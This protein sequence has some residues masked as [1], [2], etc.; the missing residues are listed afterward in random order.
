MNNWVLPKMEDLS[1]YK[2][3]VVDTETSGLYVWKGHQVLGVVLGLVRDDDKIDSRYY[4]FG[5][6]GGDQYTRQQVVE[7]L[8]RELVGKK[9]IFHNAVFDLIML[10]RMCVDLR[11]INEIHDTMFA[12]ILVNPNSFYHLD[13]M[14][15]QYVDPNVQKIVLPFPKDKM[16]EASS[17]EVGAYAELDGT[18]TGNLHPIM[19]KHISGNYLDLIYRLECDCSEVTAEM[20]NNGLCVDAAKLNRWVEEVDIE[21]KGLERAFGAVN[22]NSGLQLATK[23]DELGIGYS[24]NYSCVACS[25][26]QRRLIEW[27]AREDITVETPDGEYDDD[28]EVFA[29]E[30]YLSACPY[31]HEPC[32]AR[33][34]CMSKEGLHGLDHPYVKQVTQLRGMMRLRDTFLKPWSEQLVGNILP[35]EL[36]QLREREYGGTTNGTVTGRYSSSMIDNGAQPQ[37]IWSAE[38]QADEIGVGHI[39]RELFVSGTP[40]CMVGAAD[41]SQIEFRLFGLLAYDQEQVI[42][43][44]YRNDPYTDYHN[45][46]G[47]AI[48][49]GE[50]PRKQVKTF[51]FGSLYGM[52]L[53]TFARRLFQTLEQ[54]RLPY[55]KYHRMFPQV[56]E[57][58]RYYDRMARLD[59]EIRTVKGRLFSFG[60]KDKTHIAL[61]RLI[62]G[63]A[64]DLMKEAL[65]KLFRAGLYEKMRITVHDEVMGDL[66]PKKALQVIELLNDVVGVKLPFMPGVVKVPFRWEIDISENWAMTSPKTMKVYNNVKIGGKELCSLKQFYQYV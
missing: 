14:Y 36:N 4:P 41:A 66:D 17:N 20:V 39:L 51:N 48:L 43:D 11:Q 13:G 28:V 1:R 19:Q 58:S 30:R 5:H 29:V 26:D 62:Q 65:V 12:G 27:V 54:A 46:V 8:K 63:S 24:H 38:K 47:T 56:R 7:F 2:S 57:T 23:F 53:A 9:L 60:I 44:A 55:N 34:V 59:K 31:C 32:E 37:Q 25:K 10:L 42:G 50:F 33:S 18:M 16:Q 35:F 49:N 21:V 52:G 15:A 40:G 6:D 22:P 45:L 61:S 64:A 3:I